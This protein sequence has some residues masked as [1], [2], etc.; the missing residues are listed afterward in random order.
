MAAWK[1]GSRSYVDRLVE[2]LGDRL[3]LNHP[4]KKI[5]R[6]EG[7]VI[8]T[9]PDGSEQSFDEVILACH[10]DQSLQLLS[11]PTDEETNLLSSFPYQKNKVTLHSDDSVIP[12]RKSARASWNAFLPEEKSKETGYLRYEHF[13]KPSDR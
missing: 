12:K 10:A 2:I 7:Q 9:M 11:S 4:I 3:K 8:L 13:T 6:S 1:G 5:V